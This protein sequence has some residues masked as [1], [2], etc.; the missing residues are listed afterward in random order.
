MSVS[1]SKYVPVAFSI[2]TVTSFYTYGFNDLHYV[3]V[4]PCTMVPLYFPVLQVRLVAIG[5]GSLLV[6]DV[7]PRMV[8]AG[9]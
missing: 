2:Y 4:F 6:L 5:L 8:R 1:S 9:G 7:E 3:C